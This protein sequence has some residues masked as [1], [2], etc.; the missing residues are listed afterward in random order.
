MAY[1]HQKFYTNGSNALKTEEHQYDVFQ[2]PQFHAEHNAAH[3]IDFDEA[4]NSLHT[5]QNEW[6]Q[7]PSRTGLKSRIAHFVRNNRIIGELF[8]PHKRNTYHHE[9]LIIFAK[10]F[11]VTGITAFI[12]ILFGA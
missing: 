3:I 10:G 6:K 7:T 5:S 1:Q 11:S 9:D 12:M 2:K 4:Y 8:S